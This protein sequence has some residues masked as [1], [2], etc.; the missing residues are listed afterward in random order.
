MSKNKYQ[1]IEPPKDINASIRDELYLGRSEKGVYCALVDHL[2]HLL[3]LQIWVLKESNGL[4]EWT[5]EH[6]TNLKPLLARPH[7]YNEQS[8]GPWIFQN[9]NYYYE[10]HDKE[11]SY[12]ELEEAKID[13]DSDND[14]VVQYE[15]GVDEYHC[16]I[17]ILGFH[18]FKDVIFLGESMRRGLAYRFNT[19]K[20]QDLGN[21]CPR[22][23]GHFSRRRGHL[24]GSFP[25]TPC[26]IDELPLNS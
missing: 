17:E 7:K 10:H 21:I 4:M 15:D 19:S 5:L 23:N 14:D 6:Q 3:K 24:Y 16:Y 8:A 25:Y 12:E 20:F 18:P 11:D 13:W 9:I 22:Q 1:I 2:D 26:W